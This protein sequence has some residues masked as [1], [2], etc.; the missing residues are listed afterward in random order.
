MKFYTNVVKYGNTLL[1][2]GY[3]NGERVSER[4]PYSPTLF[5]PINRTSLEKSKYRTL[6]GNAV[7]PIAFHTMKD[8]NDF[9]EQYRHVPNFTVSGMSNY[10]LQCIGDRF[11]NEIKF[12]RERINVTTID[13]EVASDEG[14]PFPEEAHHP[15]I[16]ITCKNNIDNVYYVWGLYDYN[17]ELNDHNIT[18][19]RCD[20]EADLL[21][22]FL[23]WWSSKPNVPDILTG[24]NTQMFDVPYLVNRISLVLD[25]NH[26]KDLSPW[27][28]LKKRSI[29]NKMGQEAQVYDVFGISQLD[30]Y[31][32]FQKFGKLTYGEQ[33]SYKLDHIAYVVLGENKLSYEEYGSL[34]SLYKHDFQKFIDYNIKDVELVDRLEEKMALITLA[35]TMA[36]KAKT[37]YIDTLGTTNIWDSVIYNA[38]RPENIVVPPKVD[39]M[40]STI[41]GGYV[42][43]PVVGSHDWVCSFDLNSLYPNIIVQYNMSP[44]TLTEGEGA[45]AANGTRY[46]TDVQGIIPRVIKQFYTDRVTAKDAM[47]KA[48]QDYEKTP[49]KKLANDITIFNNQQMAVKILMNSLYG[50]MA[51]QYFRYF[52]LRIAEAVTTSGQRA[53]RCAEKAVND[54]M[55]EL[56]GTKDDYVI[57]I[58]TDSVYINFSQMVRMHQPVNPVNFLDKVCE[59]FE[60]KIADAYQQLADATNAYENRMV[61][62]REVI[63]DRGIWMAKKRYILNVHDSE[64]VR[65]AEPQLKMMGIEAIKSSTPEV[66][67]KKMREIFRV[68][69]EST[70]S[71]TQ[72]FISDFKSQFKL[73]TPEQIAFPRGITNIDKFADRDNIYSKGTPI[74][75]RGA[76]LYNHHLKKQG[77]EEKYEKIQNGEKIKFVYLKEPNRIKENVIAFPNN[78]PKEFGLTPAIDFDTMFSKS[79]VDPLTPILD[80]V[81]WSAE[82]K[83]TLEDFFV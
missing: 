8:A 29:I 57:A 47:L 71:D 69:I 25:E 10:V 49:T 64:G 26:A 6:Y 68:I 80:A 55:Q 76:L 20:T 9:I 5:V 36:Y 35:L 61:M 30:Y 39:K 67:R 62:K 41:V 24:W 16:S 81:G 77:L 65:F 43:D 23:G 42:K 3:E 38:L 21:R 46:R 17:P 50:A 74:H 52:D 79:F 44:E 31:D 2:R 27:K 28:I 7:A 59:H 78:L 19:F 40:K 83:A 48:K 54:E 73:L 45:E 58:D 1:Y 4:I 18:Y 12:D 82:P 63:A 32:L 72:R 56:M 22:S 33:E 34:H 13:I 51:N 70:E 14:F 60:N 53:I 15:V 37:N 11:P 66:I 75:A